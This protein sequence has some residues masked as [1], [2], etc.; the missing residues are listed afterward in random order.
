MDGVHGLP[1]AEV[2]FLRATAGLGGSA[3]RGVLE[4]SFRFSCCSSA[5]LASAL[6]PAQ[7]DDAYL[8]K[9]CIVALPV[10]AKLTEREASLASLERRKLPYKSSHIACASFVLSVKRLLPSM[11]GQVLLSSVPYGNML[12][13]IMARTAP[14]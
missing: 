6:Q 12:T 13:H 3:G 9:H 7:K 11:Q 8:L 1:D 5:T 4:A 14:P 2:G 10:C